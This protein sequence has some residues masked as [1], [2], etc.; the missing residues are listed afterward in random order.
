MISKTITDKKILETATDKTI[1]G[2]TIGKTIEGTI[3][4]DKIVLEMTPNKDIEKE[5]KVERV[6]RTTKMTILEVEIEVE[7]D[8]Y[9][10]ELECYQT[11][12]IGWVLGLGPIPE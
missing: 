10:K 2:I 9:N 11:I 4:T 5:V 8:K 12:E 1:G 3:E 6:P 7:R